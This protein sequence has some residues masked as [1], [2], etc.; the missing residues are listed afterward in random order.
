MLWA[1]ALIGREAG[2]PPTDLLEPER[3]E[4]GKRTHRGGGTQRG[5]RCGE[6]SLGSTAG[7]LW[8][9]RAPKG[10]CAGVLQFQDSSCLWLADVDLEYLA[11][12][13][14]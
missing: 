6:M 7:G 5:L 2:V 11:G 13:A 3:G 10:N 9:S 1:G 4:K 8:V 12:Y 14:K